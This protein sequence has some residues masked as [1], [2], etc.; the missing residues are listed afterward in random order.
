[1]I[2][3]YIQGWVFFKNKPVRGLQHS[4]LISSFT[5]N[6]I[7]GLDQIFTVGDIK[8]FLMLYTDDAVVFATSPIILQSI[9]YDIES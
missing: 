3:Y 8:L 4:I 5:V 9:L 6:I 1:M 2:K 7:V